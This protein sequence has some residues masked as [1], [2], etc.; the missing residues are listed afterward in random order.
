[1]LSH[2]AFSDKKKAAKISKD[3]SKDV[4]EPASVMDED[5]EGE[6]TSRYPS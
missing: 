5:C 3:V 4:D 6:S 1:M 2:T